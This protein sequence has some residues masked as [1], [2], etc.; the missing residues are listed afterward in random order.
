[1]DS[2]GFPPT[3]VHAHAL[4]VHYQITHQHLVFT[5]LSFIDSGVGVCFASHC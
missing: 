4:P 5:N 1:M 2:S 3:A